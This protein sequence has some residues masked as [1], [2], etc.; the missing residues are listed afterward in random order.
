M[1]SRERLQKVLNHEVPDRV[2]LDL[3]STPVTGMAVSTV[4][5]LRR[6]LGL[7]E[8]SARTK[9]VEPYQMLGEID[10]DL[11]QALGVD[12]VGL[13]ARTNLFGFENANWKPWRLFD[14]TPV[15]VPGKFNTVP[16]P[17][18]SVLMYPQG[19]TSAPASGR[20][21]QGGF[22]FDA[23]VRQPP[24]GDEALRV[25]DNL[26]EFSRFSEEDLEHL[27]QRAE[28]LYT[29]TDLGISGDTGREA[30]PRVERVA[31]RRARD[32]ACRR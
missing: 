30:R 1:T 14:G 22:Y 6:A 18:G 24:L 8:Q 3:G 4:A 13:E 7:D 32:C 20:M 23:I 2:P 25:E 21:P 5:K 16:E 26:E 31:C 29:H 15:L 28:Y 19:D 10:H 9:V 27:R 11:R 17:D 12:V